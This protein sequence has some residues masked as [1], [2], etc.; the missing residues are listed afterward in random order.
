MKLTNTVI[1]AAV[2]RMTGE[3]WSDSFLGGALLAQVGEF[4]FVL[5]AI[6]YNV[7]FITEIGHAMA[8]SVIA[9][10]LVMSPAWIASFRKFASRPHAAD[11]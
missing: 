3:R 10:T 9:I 7:G 11:G 4:S 6:G 2:L 5:S 1:N 8:V